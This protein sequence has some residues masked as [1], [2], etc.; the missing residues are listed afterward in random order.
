M[1]LYLTSPYSIDVEFNGI[2]VV[3]ID[4]QVSKIA[5]NR[6]EEVIQWQNQ[7]HTSTQIEDGGPEKA[8]R[9]SVNVPQSVANTDL[10]I[11]TQVTGIVETEEPFRSSLHGRNSPTTVY[12][13]QPPS[14]AEI[15]R[16]NEVR[17]MG[18]PR[19]REG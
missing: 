8:T 6:L 1:R 15:I 12:S 19:R 7:I 5:P 9:E 3:P 11:Q 13:T 17:M 18:G 4:P 16:S 10:R 2:V 14:Y